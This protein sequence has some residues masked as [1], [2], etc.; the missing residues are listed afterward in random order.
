VTPLSVAAEQ[1]WT[2]LATLFLDRGATVDARDVE[3]STALFR[4]AAARRLD[5]VRILIE[6][7]ADVNL[8]GRKG[9]AVIAAAAYAGSAEMVEMLLKRGADPLHADQ[10]GKSAMCY[11][12]ARGYTE[13]VRVLLDGSVDVNIHYGNGLT[14]LMWAAG[15]SVDAGIYDAIEVIK[16][17]SARGAHIDERDNRGRTALMIAAELGRTEAA[18]TLIRLGADRALVDSQGKSAGDLAPTEV[19]RAK[20][21][22]N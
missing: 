17:L 19:L 5:I 10:F 6:R 14:A 13:V 3:G 7:G 15:Y 9:N 18:E 8:P 22:G 1:G 21:A 16:L 2:E 4:A 11:A 20:L 12:A